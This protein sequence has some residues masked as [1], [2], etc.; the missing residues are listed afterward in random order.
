VILITVNTN[1]LNTLLERIAS[2]RGEIQ[3]LLEKAVQLAGDD[4]VQALSDA[5][6]QG[7]TSGGPPPAGDADGPLSESFYAQEEAPPNSPGAAVSIR[8]TQPTKL[9]YVRYGTGIYGPRGQPI[10][11]TSKQALYWPDAEH[12]VRS[13]RGMRPND[14]VQP[15]LQKAADIAQEALDIAIEELITLLE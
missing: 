2:A 15:L 3:P 13:V 14:F 7:K 4:I 1:A 8:T 12:P 11:P 6:P 5:A 10:Y 9:S